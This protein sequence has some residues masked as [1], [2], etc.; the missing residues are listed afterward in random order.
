[1]PV[2]WTQI[3]GFV[4]PLV[5]DMNVVLL[6]PAVIGPSLQEPQQFADHTVPVQAFGGD[7]RKSLREVIA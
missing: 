6:K 5:P 1:M 3:T 2:Y 4:C 7:G